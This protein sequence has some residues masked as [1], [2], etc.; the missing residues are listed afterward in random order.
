M[1]WLLP[2]YERESGRHRHRRY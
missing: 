1:N 2:I